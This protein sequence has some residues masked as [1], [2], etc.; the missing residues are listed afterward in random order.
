MSEQYLR[1]VLSSSPGL[2]PEECL[3]DAKIAQC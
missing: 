2:E 3:A 1:V